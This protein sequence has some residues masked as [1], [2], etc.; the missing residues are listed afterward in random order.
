MDLPTD[1]W[2]LKV[3]F[4]TLIGV[5]LGVG[6]AVVVPAGLLFHVHG[7]LSVDS[8]NRTFQRFD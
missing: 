8:W 2:R 7:Q 6:H 3:R 5:A 1:K 4:P